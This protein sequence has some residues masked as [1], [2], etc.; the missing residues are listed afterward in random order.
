MKKAIEKKKN[1]Y[2]IPACLRIENFCELSNPDPIPRLNFWNRF[3]NSNEQI[4][5]TKSSSQLESN[6]RTNYKF[7]KN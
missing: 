2:T 4:V 5:D 6:V 3:S 1:S 7:F